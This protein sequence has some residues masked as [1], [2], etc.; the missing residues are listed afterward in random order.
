MLLL[1]EQLFLECILVAGHL[2]VEPPKQPLTEKEINELCEEWVPESLHPP[3]TEKME[4]EPPRLE[5][6]AG[7]HTVIDGK[8][9]VSL[10]YGDLTEH[11]SQESCT[12]SLEKYGVGS[13]GPRGFYGT[14]DTHLDCEAR[15]AKFLGTPDSILYSYGISTILVRFQHL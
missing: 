14:I 9:L 7:P 10:E 5:S 12:T 3:I 6:A 11:A 2:V 4:Y 13:C 15:I 8:D 1:L